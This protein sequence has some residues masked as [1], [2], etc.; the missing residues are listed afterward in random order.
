MVC[1]IT[2]LGACKGHTAALAGSLPHV[3]ASA[4]QRKQQWGRSESG[5]A[6]IN[7]KGRNGLR[8]SVVYL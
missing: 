2:I 5:V 8:C 7:V 4:R 6:G 3:F 1:T